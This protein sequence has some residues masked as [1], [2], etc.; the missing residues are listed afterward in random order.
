MRRGN[1]KVTVVPAQS[2]KPQT[3]A[4]GSVS[5]K[6][7]LDL[8]ILG[9]LAAKANDA[10]DF[11]RTLNKPGGI[12]NLDLNEDGQVDYLK[13]TEIAAKNGVAGFSIT[14]E[15]ADSDVQEI[16]TVYVDHSSGGNQGQV[17]VQGNSQ[18]YG[19]NHYFVDTLILTG[20]LLWLF[21]PHPYYVSPYRCWGCYPPYYSRYQPVPVATYRT[22]VTS[23]TST[24]MRQTTT[25]AIPSSKAPV[26]PNAG[27]TASAI[28][29]P[30]ANPTASQQSFQQRNPSKAVATG[31]FGGGPSAAPAGAAAKP[32][33]GTSPAGAA[34][35]PGPPKA[36]ASPAPARAASGG[37][38]KK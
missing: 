19:P 13:V 8:S 1:E 5:A 22:T 17:Q 29:A 26:S 9:H 7:G 15:V 30:L 11:E 38:G 28:K 37:G 32:A 2:A 20:A 3:T 16:A 10:E 34:A 21:T 31:G 6:D 18:V 35:K 23:T 12:N 27:K 14:D 33:A 4:A 24:P 25:A 36:P